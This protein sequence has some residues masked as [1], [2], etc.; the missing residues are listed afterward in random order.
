MIKDF[1]FLKIFIFI[2]LISVLIPLTFAHSD[3]IN[4]ESLDELILNID[5]EKKTLLIDNKIIIDKNL[6]IPKNI[7]LEIG[8]KGSFY[9]KNFFEMHIRGEILGIKKKNLLF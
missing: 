4:I 5:Q 9:L 6:I 7:S 2:K 1:I 8:K 3:E